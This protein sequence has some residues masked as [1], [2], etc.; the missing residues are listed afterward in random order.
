MRKMFFFIVVSLVIQACDM[1]GSPAGPGQ[2]ELRISFADDQDALTRSGFNIPDTSDFILTVTDSKGKTMY[3]GPY[4]DS[5]ESMSLPAGNYTV[6][7]VSEKFVKPA[8]SMPQF[9]DEQCVVVGQNSVVNLKLVCVQ[10]N[11]GIRLK[12]DPG[13][14]DSYPD[15]VLLL[16]S[17]FGR[18]VYGY[19]E[20]RY[21]YFKPGNVSLVLSNEG[22][23][24]VLMTKELK[25][26]DMLDL[27]VGVASGGQAS[28]GAVSCGGISVAVDTARNWLNDSYVIG[29]G[30]SGGSGSN[31]AMTVADALKSVGSEDVWICGYIVGGDLSSSSASFSKP[32]SSRTNILLGPRSSTTD[33]GVCLSVQLPSGELRE[34]LNLV[35]NPDMLGRKVCL[36]GDVVEAYYGIPGIKNIS[37]YEVL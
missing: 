17:S 3:D 13:F 1:L 4:G 11:A 8:F 16:K 7:I 14:L 25:A 6:S 37:E 23:D 33:R 22:R 2:G 32:F 31:D 36:R 10:S 34:A 28:G 24:E 27:K 5:P 30:S 9:G 29:G 18:L 21:A 15:G 26:Q 19:A 12:V 20:K 35:D